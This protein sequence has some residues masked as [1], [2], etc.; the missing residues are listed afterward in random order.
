MTFTYYHGTSDIFLD[1]IRK[2]G[3]GKINPNIDNNHLETLRGLFELSETH[4]IDN[5][6]YRKIRDTTNAMVNQA[7][8]IFKE[9]PDEVYNFKHDGIFISLSE[10]KAIV[11]ACNNIYGSEILT[12][13]ISLMNLLDSAEID[14]SKIGNAINKFQ[15]YRT[16]P[17]KPI[18]VKI[19]K[20]NEYN[21]D[22]EDGKTAKEALDFLRNINHLLNEKE[23]FEFYQHCNFK[24]LE[25][26][27][28][29]YLEFY[30]VKCNGKIG[31]DDFNYKMKRIY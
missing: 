9:N 5:E 31:Q 3:L 1:S 20:V 26:I 28:S 16:S 13:A 27:N 6:E 4:L 24:I 14:Y 10:A 21:L 25:P 30:S 23:K 7:K 15:D 11:Y 18:V 12:R 22:K 29:N 19:N 17:P 2:N 8:L